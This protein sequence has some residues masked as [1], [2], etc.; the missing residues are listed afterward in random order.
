MRENYN[1]FNYWERF[2]DENK[3]IRGHIFMQK[4]PTQKSIYFHILIFSKKN[5]INNTWG[6]FPDIKSLLGYIQHSFLQEAFYK[7]I[8]GKEQ[9]VTKIPHSTVNTIISDGQK[10]HKINKDIALNM[11][12]DYENLNKM[13][14]MPANK[15]EMELKK[16][17]REFNR[18]WM[19]DNKEFLYIRIFKTPEELGEFVLSSS[20]M[21][22]TE[23]EVENKIG[24]TLDEWRNVC[25]FC[26]KDKVKG[27]AF[28]K[29][30]LKKLTEVF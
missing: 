18:K 23:D 19:G 6:Y 15:I 20:L 25:K 5:G 9:L 7:W 21:T 28:Q 24:M 14:D 11:K 27:E 16:F 13:W 29:V 8:Y 3:T 30:L 2:I 26:I 22:S 10:N 17:I 4:P 1:S 12:K